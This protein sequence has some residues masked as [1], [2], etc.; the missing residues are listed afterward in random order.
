[1]SVS[2]AASQREQRDQSGERAERQGS[3]ST[4]QEHRRAAVASAAAIALWRWRRDGLQHVI[5][6]LAICG[7]TGWRKTARGADTEACVDRAGQGLREN[8]RVELQVVR[9]R[10]QL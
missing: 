8:R 1:M 5:L 7:F 4:R 6:D 10:R 3:A 9:A 2:A